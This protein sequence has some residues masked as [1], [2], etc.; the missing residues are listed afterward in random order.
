MAGKS[1]VA[2]PLSFNHFLGRS[3]GD[4]MSFAHTPDR[5]RQRWISAHSPIPGLYFSGQDVVAAGISGAMVGGEQLPHLRCSVATSWM[6]SAAAP[7]PR[8]S[9]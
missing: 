1:Y 3:T 8:E 6:T 9:V 2:T 4:F 5:F 7:R